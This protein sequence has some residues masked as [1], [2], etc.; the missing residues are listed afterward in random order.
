M[1]GHIRRRGKQSW[2]LKFD[3]GVDPMTSKRRIRYCSF[4]GTK[5]AAELELARLVSEHA[6]GNS[7]DPSKITVAE[8]FDRWDRDFTAVHV[9]PKTRERY[10]QLATKQIIP[11]IGSMQL[12]NFG[13]CT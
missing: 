5:R 6:A 8:F 9:S 4:K 1:T 10:R 2:E 13:R 3:V 11:N 12:Q 7:V